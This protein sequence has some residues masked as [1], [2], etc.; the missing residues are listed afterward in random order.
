MED[1][2]EALKQPVVRLVQFVQEAWTELKKVHWPSRKETQAATVVVL[3]SVMFVALYL[4]L[5]DLVLSRLMQFLLGGGE[6]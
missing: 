6:R 5:V 3:L 2:T 4:G 1:R